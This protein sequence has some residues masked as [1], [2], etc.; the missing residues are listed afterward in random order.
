MQNVPVI[1]DLQETSVNVSTR[2]Y[3]CPN[4]SFQLQITK[5][6]QCKI[7]IEKIQEKVVPISI[8]NNTVI[9]EILKQQGLKHV[10]F[11][12]HSDVSFKIQSL[13]NVK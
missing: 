6:V 2:R 7:I 5:S 4:S 10:S 3:N 9:N 13:L 8:C 12:C 11:L 1:L